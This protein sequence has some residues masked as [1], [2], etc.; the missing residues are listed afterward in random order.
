MGKN[1]V[2]L[3]KASG[4]AGVAGQ[5]FKGNVS[6]TQAVSDMTG[7]SMSSYLLG[8][9][10]SVTGI[11]LLPNEWVYDSETTFTIVQNFASYGA[12]F[13]RIRRDGTAPWNPLG[14]VQ[15]TLN[16]VTWDEGNAN[17]TLSV[18]CLGEF[19]PATAPGVST[20]LAYWQGYTVPNVPPGSGAEYV[21]LAPVV[22]G[23]VSPSGTDDRTLQFIFDPDIAQ[24]NSSFTTGSWPLRISRRAYPGWTTLY[25]WELHSTS[26]YTDDPPLSTNTYVFVSYPQDNYPLGYVRYRIRAQYNG[27][28]AGAWTNF[29]LVSW[30]DTRTGA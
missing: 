11:P 30:S 21:V 26:A 17:V 9:D 4:N 16:S 23:G 3:I 10:G 8:T 2:E 19:D 13:F 14:T 20:F 27:G 25:E 6:P 5:T 18:T 1:L 28:T 7:F 12:N 24:F 15:H 29:G 22:T